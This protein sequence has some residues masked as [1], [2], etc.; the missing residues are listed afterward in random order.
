MK[1]EQLRT[2]YEFIVEPTGTKIRRHVFPRFDAW[3]TGNTDDAI[4][5][6]TWIDNPCDDDSGDDLSI[7]VAR[8]MRQTGDAIVDYMQN[9]TEY[10]Q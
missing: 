9:P 10:D 8:V 3:L 6:V 2:A 7:V 4:D 5:N 1:P